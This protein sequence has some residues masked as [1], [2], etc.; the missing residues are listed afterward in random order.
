MLTCIFH[1]IDGMRVLEDEEAQ[2]LID[3]GVWFD[4]PLKAREYRL[5]VERDIQS[6]KKKSKLGE[7]SNE[8]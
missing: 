7:K 3:S 8:R 2:L 5:K 6:E 4:S 1:P